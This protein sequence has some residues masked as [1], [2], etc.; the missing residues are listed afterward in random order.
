MARSQTSSLFTQSYAA[1]TSLQHRWVVD[2][3][4]AKQLIEAGA[5]L[6]DAR[7]RGAKGQLQGAIPVRWQ[8]FSPNDAIHRGQ[9]LEDDRQLTEKLQ[10]LGISADRP[11]VVFANPPEGWGED[12]R[13]VWMLRTLGHSQAVMVD[14]GF[15]ALVQA[16]VP[17]REDKPLTPMP[18]DFV[19]Q[20]NPD[21]A[22]AKEELQEQ[23][24]G[25]NVVIIDSREPREFAG[26]TPY[27]ERRGGHIPGAV[28]LYF[29]D[30]LQS[31]G[32]LL[33]QPDILRNLAEVGITGEIEVIVY[34]TGGIRSAW[35]A[36]MLVT[37][38]INVRNYAGSMWEWSASPA[39]S[40]P[41]E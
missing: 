29:K 12:G 37:L 3:T 9:L 26:K 24:R 18:G 1:E 40:Y 6:L 16:D 32:M 23:L 30:F 34:C 28:N 11:V 15:A 36:A 7:G 41:L 35:L 14:G 31:N 13:I 25:D 38:G 27:G 39:E 8:D 19:V 5:I 20:R 17:E 22:I 4:E 2:A 10:G 21:W 33:S